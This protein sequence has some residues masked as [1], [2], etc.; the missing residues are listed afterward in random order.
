MR[1]RIGKV[2]IICLFSILGFFKGSGQSHPHLFLNRVEANAMK[3][4]LGKYPLFDKSWNEAK[5]FVDRALR[6]RMDI[7]LPIDAGG[8][9]HERH[10]QNYLEMHQAGI[11]YCVIGEKRYARF[12]REM[13]LKYAEIY[14]TLGKHPAAGGE[15]SGRLFWQTL[16]ESVWL[17]H[18]TQAYDCIYDFLSEED[19]QRIEGKLIRPM[20]K[21]L[22]EDHVKELDRI[23]NHGTWTCTAVG[24]AG[25]VLHDDDL[26]DKALYGSRKDTS[27]G[28]VRQLQALF[29]PDGFYTEGL[30]YARYALLPFFTFATV[31]DKNTPDLKIF[32]FRQQ[33]LKKAF[34]SALQLTY[35]NG[36]FIPINDAMKDKN[37]LSPEIVHALDVSFMVYGRDR[38]LLSIAQKQN[39]VLLN[40]AGVAVAQAL[41]QKKTIP[42][43]PYKSVEYTDGANGD[44]GGI[45]ALRSGPNFD[46]SLVIMK[47]TGH[48]LSHGH[49]DKLALLY[50]DQ[51]REILQDYGFVRFVNVEPKYGGRYL[52]ETKSFAMQTIAHNTVTVDQQSH[53]Q[54]KISLSEKNHADRHF[55]SIADPAFQVMS[56]RVATAYPGVEIQRTTALVKDDSLSNPIVID[57]FRVRSEKLHTY[58]LPFY[59]QGHLISTN[60]KYIPSTKQMSALGTSSGY[61]HLW[62][63]AEGK[64]ANSVQVTWISGERYYTITSAADTST[65]IFFVR[66]GAGDP[67]FNLRHEP[68]FILR[69]QATSHVFASVIEPHGQWDGTNEFSMNAR[70]SIASVVVLG[71]TEEGSAV[72]VRG[73]SGRQ[74]ILL[75][76]NTQASDSAEHA[77]NINGQIYSWRGNAKL[78][79]M[80]R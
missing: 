63:E 50:Y 22:S 7:P 43:F 72:E 10:K 24:M 9:T 17:V 45:G 57:V 8:Y 67:D 65:Q 53:Y 29:S 68:A 54:G 52:P 60:V 56:A 15:S 4:A 71:S 35:T 23:H 1:F 42:P 58:D 55:F 76:T 39:S 14:P 6:Q 18:A 5:V 30:Y 26:I 47:Y 36:E 25:F 79:L 48:G 37:Y 20:A 61:Q 49:Y 40:A 38:S 21:F 19:R 34:Y 69:Q 46:Q 74:W 70:P 51:G 59:Y 31:I 27:G 62:K 32:E 66:I 33:I 80:E 44:E 75:I 64:A 12:V 16:N 78:V 73:I 2:F 13:L 28:Y 77:L 11:L 3:Q 41:V